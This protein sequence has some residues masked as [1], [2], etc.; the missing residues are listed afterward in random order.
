MDTDRH[1][2]TR[3]DTDKCKNNL[4][5]SV[6]IRVN[7]WLILYLGILTHLHAL[8]ANHE[9]HLHRPWPQALPCGEKLS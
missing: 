1:G 8:L 6:S 7:P 3:I 9:D 4:F 5:L 2:S